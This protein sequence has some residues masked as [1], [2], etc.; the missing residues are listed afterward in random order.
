[1]AGYILEVSN[2]FPGESKLWST[3]YRSVRLSFSSRAIEMV[4]RAT[5]ASVI[6]GPFQP[7]AI[8]QQHPNNL[9]QLQSF[10]I[11]TPFNV[12]ENTGDE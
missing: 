4:S 9:L 8:E 2:P 12:S 3:R 11:P 1:M 7:T 6:P 10:P 5:R